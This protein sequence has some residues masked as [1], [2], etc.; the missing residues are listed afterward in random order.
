MVRTGN[1]RVR[2]PPPPLKG[3]SGP[4]FYLNDMK[5]TIAVVYKTI[6]RKK[7]KIH[8]EVF[9]DVC[10]DDII[11]G[12]KRKPLIPHDAEIVEIGVGK[13]FE[14]RYREKYKIEETK[15]G[16]N[17]NDKLLKELQMVVN[18]QRGQ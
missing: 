3:S 8:L 10:V 9:N 6:Y 7:E 12:N 15:I 16:E 11:D 5:P 1:T 17:T 2:T 13:N 14:K 18:K 4:F